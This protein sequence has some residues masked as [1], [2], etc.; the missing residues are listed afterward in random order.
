MK[1]F[2]NY[3][4]NLGLKFLDFSDN[5]IDKNK[6]SDYAPRGAHLSIDGYRKVG[7]EIADNLD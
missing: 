4:K 3:A 7:F 2:K 5:V 6:I 1:T